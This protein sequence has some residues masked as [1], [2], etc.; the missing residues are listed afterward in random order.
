MLAVNVMRVVR[1]IEQEFL[2]DK[3]RI[4][5]KLSK[6]EIYSH[7]W[8]NQKIWTRGDGFKYRDMHDLVVNYRAVENFGEEPV[9]INAFWSALINN[10]E[11]VV[12]EFCGPFPSGGWRPAF[13]S[14][15]AVFVKHENV[16][17]FGSSGIVK[18]VVWKFR[19]ING[20]E[21]K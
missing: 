20:G 3:Y 15:A 5:T 1:R 12:G 9:L 6:E 13:L 4:V 2:P 7:K 18:N 10:F 8:P 16:V 19:K 14:H 11:G 21:C 17:S